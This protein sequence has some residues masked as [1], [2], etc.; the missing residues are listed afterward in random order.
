MESFIGYSKLELFLVDSKLEFVAK[1]EFPIVSLKRCLLVDFQFFNR[2]LSKLVEPKLLSSLV[3]PYII[4]LMLVT[5]FFQL[6]MVFG[7]VRFLVK[8]PENLLLSPYSLSF[9]CAFLPL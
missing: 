8:Y 6:I 9:L 4:Y 3:G 5:I 7:L 1:L 2:S